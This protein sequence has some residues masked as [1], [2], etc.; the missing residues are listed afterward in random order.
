MTRAGTGCESCVCVV[1]ELLH[2]Y[3]NEGAN[4]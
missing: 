4:S 2:E 1:E 3:L